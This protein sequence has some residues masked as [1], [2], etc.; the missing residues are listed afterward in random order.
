VPLR[1]RGR[2]RDVRVRVVVQEVECGRT[3]AVDWPGNRKDQP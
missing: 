1:G 3:H 2:G